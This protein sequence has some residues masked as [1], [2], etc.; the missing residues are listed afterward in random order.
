MKPLIP[1]HLRHDLP[2][3]SLTGERGLK[4]NKLRKV[5]VNQQSLPHGGA[6]IE[7]PNARDKASTWSCRSL[8]GERGLKLH[9]ARLEVIRYHRRSLTGERGLKPL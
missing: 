4:Q 1:K 5:A 6:W 7:T 9:Q 2:S 3:R 8:T